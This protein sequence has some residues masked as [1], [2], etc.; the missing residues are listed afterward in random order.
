MLLPS[1]GQQVTAPDPVSLNVKR[2][3]A[4]GCTAALDGVDP[5]FDV[6]WEY[7][8]ASG[9][10]TIA[11]PI[12]ASFD[13]RVATHAIQIPFASFAQYAASPTG[14]AWRVRARLSLQPDA[15]WSDWVNF[16]LVGAQ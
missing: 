10:Y 14:T 7:A 9:A 15:V 13:G 3:A 5:V 1:E 8:D 4:P 6:E 2:G 11:P 12:V 16:T